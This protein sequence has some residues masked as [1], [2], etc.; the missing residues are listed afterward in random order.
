[1]ASSGATPKVEHLDLS[2]DDTEALFASPSRPEPKPRPKPTKTDV[3]EVSG[4]QPRRS[5]DADNG[6][7]EVREAALRKELAGIRNINQVI[8]GVVDSLQHA[9]GSMGTVSRTVNDAFTLLN[10]WTRILSQTEHNQRL[11][12]DPSWH[13]ATQDM[14]DIENES[15]LKQQEAERRELEEVQRREA[16]AKKAEEDDRKRMEN[17]GTKSSRGSRGR[18]RGSARGGSSGRS[19]SQSGSM[20]PA[21]PGGSRVAR[22]GSGIGRGPRVRSRGI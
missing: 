4:Q 20:T 2:D 5:E 12:L 6:S 3:K 7:E 16:R 10:T 14:A 9:Q 17:A 15:L 21:R 1:M 13:G 11:I 18:G 8:E 22:A 19:T